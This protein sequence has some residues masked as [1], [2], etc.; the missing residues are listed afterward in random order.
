MGAHAFWGRILATSASIGNDDFVTSRF[1]AWISDHLSIER[2]Q[3]LEIARLENSA[4]SF[5][6]LGV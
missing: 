4:A 6:E 5:I 1:L 2:F 3:S